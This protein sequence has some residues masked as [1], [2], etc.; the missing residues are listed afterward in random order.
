MRRNSAILAAQNHAILTGKPWSPDA[1][2]KDWPTS[3]EW[4]EMVFNEQDREDRRIVHR[5]MVDAG[6]VGE[7]GPPEP[8]SRSAPATD[9]PVS[10]RGRSRPASAATRAMRSKLVAFSHRV[11]GNDACPCPACVSYWADKQDKQ[12]EITR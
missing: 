5:A 8:V 2:F 11:A 10:S 9:V 4:T 12:R 3:G 1:P 6:L 7:I